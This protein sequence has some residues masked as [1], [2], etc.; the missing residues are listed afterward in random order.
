MQLGQIFSGS[1]E[2]RVSAAS[3]PV[4]DT[5]ATGR[6]DDGLSAQRRSGRAVREGEE[7]IRLGARRPRRLD[8]ERAAGGRRDERDV[9]RR[10]AGRRRQHNGSRAVA[11]AGAVAAV[12][13]LA[14]MM[15]MRRRLVMHHPVASHRCVRRPVAH[16][17]PHAVHVAPEALGVAEAHLTQKSQEDEHAAEAEQEGRGTTHGLGCYADRVP[18][19][20]RGRPDHGG[21]SG[22]VVYSSGCRNRISSPAKELGPRQ[23]ARARRREATANLS[24]SAY[25]ELTPTDRSMARVRPRVV[26]GR[27]GLWR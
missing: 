16:Q 10:R 7:P 21:R 9:Q 1:R 23:P 17:R 20:S 27:H 15:L 14:T 25:L 13:A 18:G 26:A 2:D 3:C 22:S 8:V 4:R 19:E 6:S 5:S 11:D 12:G 24:E